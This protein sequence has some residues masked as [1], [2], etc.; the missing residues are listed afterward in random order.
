MKKGRL[1]VMR[2]NLSFVMCG[3]ETLCKCGG[4]DERAKN[5]NKLVICSVA[6]N[7]TAGVGGNCS[8]RAEEEVYE[9][10]N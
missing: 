7:R 4:G 3:K 10:E 8:E 5:I 1:L 6:S 9:N 2:K